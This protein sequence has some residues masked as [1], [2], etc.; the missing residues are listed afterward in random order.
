MLAR[1]VSGASQFA[2]DE[3]FSLFVARDLSRHRERQPR[4]DAR[5]PLA[6]SHPPWCEER[7][8]N[9]RSW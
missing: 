1:P 4:N 7:C 2:F 8:A 5:H 6:C 9:A 3:P